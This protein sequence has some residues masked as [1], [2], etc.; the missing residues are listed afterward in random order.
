MSQPVLHLTVGPNGAGKS[1]W[2]TRVIGPA[3]RLP[4]V[5]ADQIA[6]QRWPGEEMAHAYDAAEAAS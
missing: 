3:T 6:A 1:T 2:F 4:F 5:N